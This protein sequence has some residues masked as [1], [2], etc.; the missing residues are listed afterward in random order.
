MKTRLEG[1]WARTEMFWSGKIVFPQ[2]CVVEN[3]VEQYVLEGTED[4]LDIRISIKT[5]PASFAVFVS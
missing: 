3:I 1:L 2:P 4:T 5:T